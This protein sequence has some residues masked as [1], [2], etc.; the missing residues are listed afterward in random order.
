MSLISSCLFDNLATEVAK[1]PA[2]LYM[3]HKFKLGAEGVFAPA[4]GAQ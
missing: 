3:V 2:V 1:E 4:F